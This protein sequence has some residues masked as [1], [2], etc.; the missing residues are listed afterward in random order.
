MVMDDAIN[1]YQF[2][3]TALEK[4]TVYIVGTTG[5]GKSTLLNYLIGKKLKVVRDEFGTLRLELVDKSD[6]VASIGKG[7][8]HSETIYPNIYRDKQSGLTYV[9][10]PGDSDSRGISQQFLNSYIKSFLGRKI[11]EIQ[12]LIL[13]P[14]STI[15]ETNGTTFRDYLNLF[16][17]NLADKEIMKGYVTFI[18]T[19]VD[20]DIT[21]KKAVN[22]LKAIFDSQK[23]TL[24][25]AAQVLM[26]EVT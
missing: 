11:G 10:N 5:A 3:Q 4:G 13:F 22:R 26:K 18:F 23:N 1:N 12:I 21:Q 17:E 16:C 19:R 8:G 7:N 9:D 25:E 20:K 24:S 14:Y 2:D 15:E 6:S